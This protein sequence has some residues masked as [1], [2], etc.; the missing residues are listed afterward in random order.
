MAE[1]VLDAAADGNLGRGP[2]AQAHDRR[3]LVGQHQALGVLRVAD[4]VVEQVPVEAVHARVIVVATGAALPALE[5]DGGVV[6]I[7]LAAAHR[8]HLMPGIQRHGLSHGRRGGE[9]HHVQAVG[10]VAGHKGPVAGD[11]Q[12]A[13][14]TAAELHPVAQA[15]EEGQIVGHVRGGA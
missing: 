3:R 2:D 12:R 14:A 7:H 9:V 4:A 15:V 6:E 13:R 1:G 11:D 5:A 8:R 10:E